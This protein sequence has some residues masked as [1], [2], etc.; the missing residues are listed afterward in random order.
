MRTKKRFFSLLI[1]NLLAVGFLAGLRMTAPDMQNTVDRYYDEQHLMDVRV[2]S[3]LGLTRDDLEA[4]R[5][6][7]GVE[8]AEP[9][10]SFEG[11][12]GDATAD[13]FSVPERINQ[14]VLEEGR[15]PQNDHECVTEQKMLEALGIRIGDEITVDTSDSY[16]RF[17]GDDPLREHTFTIVGAVRSPQYITVARN[18]SSMGSGQVT[19]FVAVPADAFAQEYYTSI[20]LTLSGLSGYNCYTDAAYIDAVNAFIDDLEPLGEERAALRRSQLN[21]DATLSDMLTQVIAGDISSLTIDGKWYIL[22]REMDQYYVEFS[23]DSERMSNLADV[24]PMVFFLVAALS[25]L[26]SMTRMV[27]EHRAEIGLMKA[28]GFSGLPVSLKYMGYAA[29]ASLTGG[30]AGLIIGCI[31]LPSLIYY[32]W[33]ILYILPR[34]RIGLSPVV[35]LYSLG[36]AMLATAGAALAACYTTLRSSPAVLLRPRA[37]KAGRRVFLER[38]TPVWS[39][40]SFIQK[41]SARNLFRY[42][43]RFW[44]TIAGIAGCT[45]LLVTG[46]GLRDSIFDVLR[47]QFD[48]LMMYDATV[49]IESDMVSADKEAL[50]Q[51]FADEPCIAAFSPCFED[52]ISLRTQEGTLE[53]VYLTASNNWDELGS[54]IRLY[55]RGGGVTRY[56]KSEKTERERLLPDDDSVI[57]DEKMAEMMKVDV[58]DTIWLRDVQDEEYPVLVGEVC[59]NYVNHHVYMTSACYK[60]V[61]G[62]KPEDNT[63]LVALNEGKGSQAAGGE[64]ANGDMGTAGGER[65]DG[66]GTGASLDAETI[67]SWKGV[68]TYSRIDEIRTR[69]ED[70]MESLNVVVL[71][72]ILA[73]A[74]LAFLVLFN[75][76][77]INV[78]ERI[79]ELATLKVLGFYDNETAAYVYRENMLLTI[80]GS[81]LGLGMGKWLHRWLIDTIEVEYLIF[82]RSVH[83]RSFAYAL[84]L[85]AVFS[86]SVNVFSNYTIRRID[87]VESLK[88]VE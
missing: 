31:C 88:S 40:L 1:M 39:R 4:L 34:L 46:F 35:T 64:R 17:V 78:T 25:S 20:Y 53:N 15:L 81:L 63:V 14:L 32:E 73:A 55:P 45:A 5:A 41:V 52:T 47:W 79:R 23:S 44:M 60:S 18:T 86:L 12:V 59:E 87:M 62:E 9:G 3:T 67:L 26:T 16:K 10:Y 29:G 19:G 57:I 11:R 24:F 30:L 51:H 27:E 77:N 75:L 49:G 38:I 71:I 33:G 68:L 21:R 72:I 42:Q 54:F 65:A 74:I 36:A 76:T 58:G 6:V 69:F 50:M 61:Y 13:I 8:E 56:G 37:P 43:K 83:G 2:V 66:E 48:R 7:K 28:L 84:L 85:T 70:S 22:S 82:G 80:L